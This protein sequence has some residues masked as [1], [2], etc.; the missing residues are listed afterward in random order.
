MNVKL[1]A[2]RLPMVLVNRGAGVGFTTGFVDVRRGEAGTFVEVYDDGDDACWLSK[3]YLD[4]G[5]L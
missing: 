3:L 2:R 5:A 4:E 1:M